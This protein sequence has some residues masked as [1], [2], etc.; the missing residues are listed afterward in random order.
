MMQPLSRAELKYQ[1]H[2]E[3]MISNKFHQ[4]P[5]ISETDTIPQ[6]VIGGLV[7]VTIRRL[8]R[9][10]ALNDLQQFRQVAYNYNWS[11]SIFTTSENKEMNQK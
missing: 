11:T 4:L 10:I 6:S 5:Q 8:A 2:N 1:E 7:I 9:R 3:D